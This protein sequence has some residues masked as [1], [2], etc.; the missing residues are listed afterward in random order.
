MAAV[1]EA[2][3]TTKPRNELEVKLGNATEKLMFEIREAERRPS[4]EGEILMV[5]GE[6]LL[7]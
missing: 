4:N 1:T 5:A 7:S 2:A 6:I 3:F